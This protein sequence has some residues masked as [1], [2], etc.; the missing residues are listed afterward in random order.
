MFE[1]NDNLDIKKELFLDSII[2]T[3]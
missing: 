1:L 2:Y 3:I